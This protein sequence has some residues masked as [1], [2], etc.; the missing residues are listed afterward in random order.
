V[1]TSVYLTV[2]RAL[3]IG[4]DELTDEMEQLQERM[5]AAGYTAGVNHLAVAGQTSDSVSTAPEPEREPESEK[6]RS[7]LLWLT[8]KVLKRAQVQQAPEDY[9]QSRWAHI[10]LMLSKT[11]DPKVTKRYQTSTCKNY[12]RIG[13]QLYYRS[14]ADGPLRLVVANNESQWDLINYYHTHVVGHG[15]GTRCC[16]EL[17]RKFMWD[18]MQEMCQQVYDHCPACQRNTPRTARP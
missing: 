6:E 15:S 14:V 18:K 9:E 3:S 12:R 10:Y 5:A 2:G 1:F 7:P 4:V 8:H 16:Y 13:D 11:G 17:T